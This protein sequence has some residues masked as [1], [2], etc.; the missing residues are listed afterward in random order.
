MAKLTDSELA[1]NV[2]AGNQ[3]RAERRRERLAAAG[4]RQLVCWITTTTRTALELEA[5]NRGL[6]VGQTAAALLAEALNSHTPAERLAMATAA[7]GKRDAAN[8]HET[9]AR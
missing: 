8:S 1:A 4:R 9:A 6:P 7:A 2:R 5:A 3:R